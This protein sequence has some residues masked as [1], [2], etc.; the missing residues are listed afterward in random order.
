MSYSR[1]NLFLRSS[2][3]FLYS[4]ISIFIYSL[5]CCA[6]RVFPLSVRL[7]LVVA[8]LKVYFVVLKKV[9]LLDYRVEGLEHIPATQNGIL[10]CK[11]SSVWETFFLPMMFH[12]PAAIAKKE[13]AYVPFFGWGFSATDPIYIN[14][15]DK[16]GAIKEILEKGERC[17]QSG[18]WI[19]VF[20]EGTRVPYG[21]IGQYKMGGAR[22]AVTSG[23]PILPIAHNAGRFWPRR[24]FIK[25]P[26]TVTVVIGPLIETKGRKAEEVLAEAKDWIETTM[27]RI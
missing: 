18:R 15:Q 16:K 23:Y 17:L 12:V 27:T 8:Y 19:M 20:P 3:F 22:L 5:V 10:M 25:Q 4:I 11:H 7:K 14:R 9:C 6:A 13:L 26:G 24:Q 1:I 21:E 2:I